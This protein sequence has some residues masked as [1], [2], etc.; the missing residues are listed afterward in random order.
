ML[1]CEECRAKVL[2]KFHIFD[3]KGE[4]FFTRQIVNC[5]LGARPVVIELLTFGYIDASH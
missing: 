4:M 2:I 5:P 3:F 1:S